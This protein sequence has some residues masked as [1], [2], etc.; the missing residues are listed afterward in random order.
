MD[1]LRKILYQGVVTLMSTLL[2][3]REAVRNLL[4]MPEVMDAVEQAFKAWYSGLGN[5]PPKAYLS[6]EKGDFRAMPA[7][8]PGCA[9]M[10]WV[11]AHPDNR[12]E[13]LPAVMAVIIYNDPETGYPLAIME[14]A[15]ITAYRTGAATAIASK[16]L[17][18][19]DSRSLGIIGAGCQAY[20]QI[21]AHTA[22]FTFKAINIFDIS[23]K[24]IDRVIQAFPDHPIRAC[25]AEEAAH[26]I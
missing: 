9:G 12:G 21:A 20:T 5:M 16:Y 7:S 13:N 19:P 10:K 4:H 11:N 17:A 3:D 8:L 24:A 23:Q 26:V 25:S 6:V 22:L 15:Q 2:L 1:A 18:R 14:G